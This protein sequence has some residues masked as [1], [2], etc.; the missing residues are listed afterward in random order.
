MARL[1]KADIL[2][3]TV[4]QLTTLWHQQRSVS[5]ATEVDGYK[6]GFKD[7]ARETIRYLSSTQALDTDSVFHL[8]NHLQSCYMEKTRKT[9]SMSHFD[10]VQHAHVITSPNDR[11]STGHDNNMKSNPSLY[12]RVTSSSIAQPVPDNYYSNEYQLYCHPCNDSLDT[13]LN[14]SCNMS[15]DSSSNLTPEKVVPYQA[16]E[17]DVW[18]PW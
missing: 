6:K 14:S 16:A 12:G 1:D 7:C 5:L 3:L 17:G 15:L 4:R 2:E 8:N 18:R 10:G 13:S 9:S 11:Q